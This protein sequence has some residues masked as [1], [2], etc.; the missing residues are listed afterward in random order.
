MSDCLNQRVLNFHQKLYSYALTKTTIALGIH[1][2]I[3]PLISH[4]HNN[5]NPSEGQNY[6]NLNPTLTLTQTY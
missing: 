6:S 3:T 1:V 2:L 5:P 4:N